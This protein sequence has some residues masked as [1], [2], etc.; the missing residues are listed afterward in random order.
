VQ[1]I[2]NDEVAAAIAMPEA[3]D[4]MRD[5]FA[6]IGQGSVD[7]PER[8][9]VESSDG[10][11][12]VLFMPGQLRATR[13][14]GLK[15]VSV[16]PR[17]PAAHA[18]PTISATVLVL[19]PDTGRVAALLD[20]A[21]ITALRTGAVTGLAT[22]LLA[23]QNV[24]TLAVFGAGGQAPFQIE[25]VCRVRS[26]RRILMW[27]PRAE[28][29]AA[30]AADIATRAKQ[31]IR[32]EVG[33]S[34]DETAEQ[35]DV[36]V[37]ATTSSVPLFDGRLLQ[38]GTHVNAIGAFKPEVREVDDATVARA[39]IFVD[40]RASAMKEAGDLLIPLASGVITEAAIHGDLAD[41]VLGR[42]PGRTSQE[43][44]TFFKSVGLAAEDLIVAGRVL[45]KTHGRTRA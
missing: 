3:I 45:E 1:L 39:R 42:V 38:R 19:D 17:N 25:A 22:D 13:R 15:V 33:R 6:Q 5:L 2:T 7:L 11:D 31:G 21:Y 30:L 24:E 40:H 16:F 23:R 10:R 9:H 18:L 37:T 28:R 20:G 35:A 36:I 14:V 34:P 4:L 44:I 29:A 43:D 41:L 12:V 26:F 32:V 8:I 27:S